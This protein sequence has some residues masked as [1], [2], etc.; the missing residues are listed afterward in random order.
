MREM[1]IYKEHSIWQCGKVMEK[2]KGEA[3]FH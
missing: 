2:G 1:W 3:T